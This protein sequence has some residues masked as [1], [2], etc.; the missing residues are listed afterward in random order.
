M[1]SADAVAKTREQAERAIVTQLEDAWKAQTSEG[2]ITNKPYPAIIRLNGKE[3]R[4]A[5]HKKKSGGVLYAT[6]LDKTIYGHVFTIYKVSGGSLVEE[7]TRNLY[8]HEPS[9]RDLQIAEFNALFEGAADQ[10]TAVDA[11]SS[12]STSTSSEAERRPDSAQDAFAKANELLSEQLNK[13]KRSN[14]R[15]KAAVNKAAS[16]DEKRAQ[17]DKQLAGEERLRKMR[18]FIFEAEDALREAFTTGRQELFAKYAELFQDAAGALKAHVDQSTST[19]IPE[20]FHARINQS[21]RILRDAERGLLAAERARGMNSIGVQTVAD[22]LREP[23]EGA[24]TALAAVQAAA[25]RNGV[26]FSRALESFGGMP[27]LGR[28]NLAYRKHQNASATEHFIIGNPEGLDGETDDGA[29]E[30]ARNTLAVDLSDYQHVTDALAAGT[31]PATGKPFKAE[32]ERLEAIAEHCKL[33]Q[34]IAGAA[35]LIGDA[36]TIALVAEVVAAGERTRESS[37]TVAPVGAELARRAPR[38]LLDLS[39]AD[40]QEITEAAKYL[41]DVCCSAQ[42]LVGENVRAQVLLSSALAKSG[43]D[44]LLMEAFNLDRDAAHTIHNRLDSR[45]SHRLRPEDVSDAYAMFPGL[46]AVVDQAIQESTPKAKSVASDPAPAPANLADESILKSASD[47]RH[48]EPQAYQ[49]RQ[50]SEEQMSLFDLDDEAVGHA[51]LARAA[52]VH[53]KKGPRLGM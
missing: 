50:R 45:V 18:L 25:E 21:L 42:S 23:V 39:D 3:R 22:D 38:S 16:M 29:I 46:R 8:A 26:D 48:G 19:A 5:L 15:Y 47:A 36:E 43:R 2:F 10:R 9:S 24:Y 1:S 13:Q 32:G 4:M 7:G 33:Q 30:E 11:E 35:E 41:K 6:S 49:G 28:F 53:T 14:A 27:D 12:T 34:S 44:T 31:H 37:R 52:A 20:R 17:L 40:L 51:G